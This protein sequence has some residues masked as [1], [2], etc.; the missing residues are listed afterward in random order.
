MDEIFFEV[1]KDL[2]DAMAMSS[3]SRNEFIESFQKFTPTKKICFGES[4]RRCKWHEN[5]G[6]P[7]WN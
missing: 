2:E 1:R 7:E 3:C 6:C 5:G 4:C